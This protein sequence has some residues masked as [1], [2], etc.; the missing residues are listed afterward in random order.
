MASS[1]KAESCDDATGWFTTEDE[2]GGT[3][4]AE[5]HTHEPSS[6]EDISVREVGGGGEV[7]PRSRSRK[8]E[9]GGSFA[10]L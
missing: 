5:R 2:E 9:E 8:R 3:G 10:V 1:T 4:R 6:E 7:V